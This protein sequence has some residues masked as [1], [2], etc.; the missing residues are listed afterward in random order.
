MA[1][2]NDR[3]SIFNQ[4]L[5]DAGCDEQ[6]IAKCMQ[7]VESERYSGLLPLLSQHRKTLL[8]AVHSGQ[9]QIDCLDYLVYQIQK[10]R[11]TNL[12]T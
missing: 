6:T 7:M 11:R 5:I 2:A 1:E 4:N 9:K 12:Q 8:A 3:V 10:N